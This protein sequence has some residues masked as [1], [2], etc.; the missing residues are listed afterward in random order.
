MEDKEGVK[1]ILWNTYIFIVTFH[2]VW[3]LPDKDLEFQKK[4][5]IKN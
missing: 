2:P 3:A 4:I 1:I 5:K